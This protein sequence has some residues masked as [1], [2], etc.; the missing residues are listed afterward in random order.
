M[1]SCQEKLLEQLTSRISSGLGS[2]SRILLARCIS[3]IFVIS[4][5][6]NLFKTINTCNDLLKAKEDSGI[7]LQTKL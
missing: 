6:Y 7:H 5:A 1:K 3:K 4:D 2:P